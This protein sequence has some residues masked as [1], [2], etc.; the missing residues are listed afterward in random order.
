MADYRAPN[1]ESSGNMLQGMYVPKP[2]VWETLYDPIYILLRAVHRREFQTSMDRFS[3]YTKHAGKFKGS[4]T[5]WPPFR[6]PAT[7][8]TPYTD[9]RHMLLSKAVQ[10]VLFVIF[11]KGVHTTQLSDQVVALAVYL[12]EMALSIC[13]SGDSS[14][15]T[16]HEDDYGRYDM[17][18]ETWYATDDL[19]SNLRMEVDSVLVKPPPDLN[20]TSDGNLTSKIVPL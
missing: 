8:A 10:G 17:N 20:G 1:F 19:L 13:D 16:P 11:Y 14:V 9:P 5:P 6:I 18:F 2:F 3:E 15:I 7:A 12:L 4:G